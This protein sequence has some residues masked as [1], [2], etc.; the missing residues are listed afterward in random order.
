MSAPGRRKR[1]EPQTRQER[2]RARN[3][4]AA[5]AH[6]C[7]ASAIRRGLLIRPE[8]CEECGVEAKVDAHHPDHRDPLRVQFLCRRCHAAVHRRGRT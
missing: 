4:V 3:E 2:W 5:W 1:R 7:T 8:Q 6:V